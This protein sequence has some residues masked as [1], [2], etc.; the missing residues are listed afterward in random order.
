MNVDLVDLLSF[1]ETLGG[2]LTM[3]VAVVAA[4]AL[5]CATLLAAVTL[6]CTVFLTWRLASGICA[7][8]PYGRRIPEPEPLRPLNLRPMLRAGRW[9]WERA[10]IFARRMRTWTFGSKL[11]LPAP[12]AP[13]A[14]LVLEVPNDNRN[15]SD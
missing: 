11:A 6:V 12:G 1:V 2:S 4:T 10:S 7:S 5:A 15:E 14:S 3:P 9:C 13:V 8:D